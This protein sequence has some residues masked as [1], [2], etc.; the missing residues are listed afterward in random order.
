MLKHRDESLLDA[1]FP[2]GWS[3]EKHYHI[4]LA[5]TFVALNGTPRIL[6]FHEDHHTSQALSVQFLSEEE[7]KA[8]QKR[9][10]GHAAATEKRIE[11]MRAHHLS[12]LATISGLVDDRSAFTA[13]F[14]SF[15]EQRGL[16]KRSELKK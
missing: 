15:L 9:F 1:H 13:L 7:G 10:Q 5:D 3:Q 6:V 2:H 16:D 14:Q 4:H 11:L 12:R 8:L